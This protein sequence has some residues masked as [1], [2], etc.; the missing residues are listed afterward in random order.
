MKKKSVVI[1]ISLCLLL[2][3]LG[4]GVFYL[5]GAADSAPE[6]DYTF[7]V[8][9]DADQSE[10]EAEASAETE[11]EQGADEA[12]DR[13]YSVS[14]SS[15]IATEIGMQVL[16]AGGNAVDAAVAVA[17]TLAVVEPYGSGLGGSGG[18]LV[19]DMNTG[20]CV[21]YDY[22]ASAGS[23]DNSYDSI[24]VPG[25]V[26]GMEA[27]HADYGTVSM[28]DLLDPAIY[29]AENGFTVS[30]QLSY[31]LTM[32][33]SDLSGYSWLYSEDGDYLTSGDT[34]YQTQLAE[35]LRAIQSEGAE[36]FYSGW[37]AEDIAAATSLTVEDLENYQVYKRDAV[38]GSF[39]GYTVYSA[40]SPLSGI[41]LI[42]M[43]EMAEEL[44]ISDPAEDPLTYLAQLKQITA[45][46]YGNR[47]NTI[48]DQSFY[49]LD[50]QTLVSESY[51]LDLLGL[52]YEEEGYDQ[53]YESAET[54]SFSIVDSD[55]LVVVATNTLT[56][57]WGSRIA[58][59]GIFM[60]STNNNFSSSGLN[61]YEPGKRSRTYT[62]PTIVTGEGGYVIAIGTPG[63]NNIPSRLFTVLV[64]ILKFGEEPQTAIEKMGLLYRNG[65]LTIEMDENNETWFDTSGISENI[66]WKST[67]MWWGAISLAGYSDEQGAF[68]AYDTR[69]GAT[70]SGV[71]NPQ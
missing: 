54:T 59:D 39:E 19:Y 43:L 15:D 2:L 60:N 44:D 24:A 50:E 36:V 67:G 64:D 21:F 52:S 12:A 17:Y 23:T 47:Y 40:N 48:G 10:A 29:Y 71:Y 30:E 65:V 7:S 28:A 9:L 26:A 5:W 31:R 49:A 13:S 69:R 25:F 35:V 3:L 6:S 61:V 68:S 4:G 66:V 38:E 41:T 1:L 20:E 53:D 57:F 33:K 45:L 27:C 37:I 18:L 32:A 14:T 51:I 8:S 34:M 70:M 55:G 56:Q 11:E 58:V 63:G 46:A 16:E 42:Q 62:A 22:R